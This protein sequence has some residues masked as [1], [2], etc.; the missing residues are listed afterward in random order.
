[1][2]VCLSVGEDISTPAIFTSFYACC[3]CS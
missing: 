2:N 3:L 1:M